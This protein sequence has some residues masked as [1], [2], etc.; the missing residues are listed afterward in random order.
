MVKLDSNCKGDSNLNSSIHFFFFHLTTVFQLFVRHFSWPWKSAVTSV[1]YFIVGG[2]M[3][4][5]QINILC[6]R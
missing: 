3:N 4:N 5:E 2:E 1:F 6:T